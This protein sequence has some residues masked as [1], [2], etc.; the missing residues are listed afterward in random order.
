MR[1]ILYSDD[2]LFT[3][4]LAI[5]LIVLVMPM[6]V[7]ANDISSTD[8]LIIVPSVLAFALL[9]GSRSPKRIYSCIRP[10]L[11]GIIFGGLLFIVFLL[12]PDFNSY[13]NVPF[14]HKLVHVWCSHAFLYVYYDQA[15]KNCWPGPESLAF[16]ADLQTLVAYP[17]YGIVITIVPYTYPIVVT[18]LVITALPKHIFTHK[19]IEN[20][21]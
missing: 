7:F 3:I 9:L 20:R 10:R 14:P 18:F 1:N 17:F 4:I 21:I 15:E 6:L 16:M 5:T 8:I 13:A 2:L 11:G 12:I 19:R